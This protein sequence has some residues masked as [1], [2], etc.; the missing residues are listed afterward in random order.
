MAMLVGEL[1]SR[2]IVTVAAADS[3]LEAVHRM[4]Q[5]KIRHLPVLGSRGELVGV[6]TDRDLRHELFEPR[7]LNAAPIVSFEAVLR[8]LPVAHAMSTPAMTVGPDDDLASAAGVMMKHRI[9]SLPV[10]QGGEV[11]GMLTESD[12]LRHLY[13]AAGGAEREVAEIVVSYP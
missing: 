13:A 1:M 3:C 11:V 12:L 9:G 4:A 10:V 5:G 6:V 7:V 2:E 8:A